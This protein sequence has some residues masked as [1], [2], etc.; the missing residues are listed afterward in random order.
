MKDTIGIVSDC[1]L[2]LVKKI[3]QRFSFRPFVNNAMCIKILL[4]FI[5]S[6]T[7]SF[8]TSERVCFMLRGKIK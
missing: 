4:I 1:F 7:F 6:F 5:F 8:V 3:P 2:D